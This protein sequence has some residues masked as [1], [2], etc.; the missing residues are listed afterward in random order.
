MGGEVQNI[1]RAAAAS[2]IGWWLESGVDAP[3]GES[4]R[5]WLRGNALVQEPTPQQAT[6]VAAPKVPPAL[7]GD[8]DAVLGE[9]GLGADD[10][11]RLREAKV[12]V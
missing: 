3:V 8:T 2:L 10:V 1:D 11:A 6:P 9:L 12:I 7:G 5:D 4:P